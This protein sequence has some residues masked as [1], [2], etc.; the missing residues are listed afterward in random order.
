MFPRISSY[1]LPVSVYMVTK[2]TSQGANRAVAYRIGVQGVAIPV[3]YRL[4]PPRGLHWEGFKAC[5]K[6]IV[7]QENVLH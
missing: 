4:F 6:V 5:G 3:V 2:C 7:N 1:I